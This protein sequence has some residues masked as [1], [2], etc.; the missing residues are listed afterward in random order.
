M[1]RPIVDTRPRRRVPSAPVLAVVI[2][3]IGFAVLWVLVEPPGESAVRSQAG[4]PALI[5]PGPATPVGTLPSSAS[6]AT[7]RPWRP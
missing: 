4:A 6:P 2:A 3:L 1:R 5:G 7:P